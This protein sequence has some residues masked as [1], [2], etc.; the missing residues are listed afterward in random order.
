MIGVRFVLAWIGSMQK[1]MSVDS[2]IIIWLMGWASR[3]VKSLADTIMLSIFIRCVSMFRDK[4]MSLRTKQWPI[5]I[6]IYVIILSDNTG[7]IEWKKTK[8]T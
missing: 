3:C 4:L 6:I 2:K 5:L 7:Q 8:N 1:C